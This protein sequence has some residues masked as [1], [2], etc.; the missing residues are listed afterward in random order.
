MLADDPIAYWRLGEQRRAASGTN[1]SGD[2][3]E[4]HYQSGVRLGAPGAV[5]GDTAAGFYGEQGK[6]VVDDAEGLR[7]NGSFSIEFW[8]RQARRASTAWPGVLNMN[9]SWTADGY[10]IW[11]SA[12]GRLILKRNNTEWSTPP[13]AMSTDQLRHFVVTYDGSSVSWYV[14]GAP[15]ATS[16]ASIPPNRGS[17]P[18]ELGA[19]DRGQSGTLLLDEVAL[20]DSA[21]SAAS[22][23]AHREAADR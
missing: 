12:D 16:P 13:G 10:L 1:A 8:A 2:G 3:H 20:Y 11:Y 5:P 4:A 14:D 21:L 6:A 18:L 9:G 19:G 17:A 22:V 15:V 23:G 7:L